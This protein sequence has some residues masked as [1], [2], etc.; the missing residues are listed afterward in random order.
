MCNTGLS[1]ERNSVVGGHAHCIGCSIQQDMHHSPVGLLRCALSVLFEGLDASL[2]RLS[3]PPKHPHHRLFAG[4]PEMT[5]TSVVLVLVAGAS[6]PASHP[7]R[8]SNILEGSLVGEGLVESWRP[9]RTSTSTILR[10]QQR[11]ALVGA[12][13]TTTTNPLIS[14][15]SNCTGLTPYFVALNIAVGWPH[16]AGRVVPKGIP[17]RLGAGG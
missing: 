16:D 3:L 12:I 15:V 8:F 5:F 10:R 6:P 2:L 11:D 7:S 13:V 4:L 17:L 14:T 9:K 1:P